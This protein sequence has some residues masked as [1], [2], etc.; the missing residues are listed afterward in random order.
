MFENQHA[1]I[2]TAQPLA[3]AKLERF[4]EKNNQGHA[5]DSQ[6][7][8][9]LYPIEA[10]GARNSE[11]NSEMD[12]VVKIEKSSSEMDD[13][14]RSEK[15]PSTESDFEMMEIGEGNVL[16][17]KDQSTSGTSEFEMMDI[18]ESPAKSV[19]D[20]EPIRS[21]EGT[22]TTTETVTEE[23]GASS[24]SVSADSDHKF[25]KKSNVGD[26]TEEKDYKPGKIFFFLLGLFLS[27][28]AL[29]IYNKI[30]YI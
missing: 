5:S 27:Q 18:E 11:A 26:E 6:M 9:I 29:Q 12:D 10:K 17:V 30:N 24:P 1:S 25:I 7:K 21:S 28:M 4:K 3:D 15:E 19:S 22:E 23:V 13:L 2:E 16:P 20:S 14:V 8:D